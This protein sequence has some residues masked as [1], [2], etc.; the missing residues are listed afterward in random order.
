M[1][2]AIGKKVLVPIDSYVVEIETMYG[3]ADG[4]GKIIVGDFKKGEE[5]YLE[6]LLKT[7]N[8]MK[9]EYPYGRGGGE[10]YNHVEGF[11]KWFDIDD[12]TEEEY[13]AIPERIKNDLSTYWE[14]DPQGDGTHASYDGHKVFYY[15]ENGVKYK[16]SVSLD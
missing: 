6:D 2:I 10:N 4:Y 15:D 8:R 11:N 16:V 9:D 3:D 1:N 14:Y 13:E 7:C 12:T 5:S